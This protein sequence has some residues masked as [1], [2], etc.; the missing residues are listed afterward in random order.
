VQTVSP[1]VQTLVSNVVAGS[2]ITKGAAW[3]QT[4]GSLPSCSMSPD[5]VRIAG[6]VST[7]MFLCHAEGPDAERE[8][9]AKMVRGGARNH[10][11]TLN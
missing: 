10:D 2:A 1:T 9:R 6:P 11:I 8:K 5:I 4:T 3:L 7:G